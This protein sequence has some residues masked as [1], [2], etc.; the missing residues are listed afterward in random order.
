VLRVH[1]MIHEKITWTL[2]VPGVC[3]DLML[4]I[5]FLRKCSKLNVHL[6]VL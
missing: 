6:K 1:A 5:Y 4:F 2:F 3:Y